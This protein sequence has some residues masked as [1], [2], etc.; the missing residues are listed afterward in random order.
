MQAI[1]AVTQFFANVSFT[2]VVQYYG[3][4]ILRN[5][6]RSANAGLDLGLFIKKNTLGDANLD[7]GFKKFGH[8]ACVLATGTAAATCGLAG[9][10]FGIGHTVWN[11]LGNL[12]SFGAITD[13]KKFGNPL[14]DIK[15][16]AR[17]KVT[18]GY[19]E[20]IKEKWTNLRKN[21]NNTTETDA[22]DK[23]EYLEVPVLKGILGGMTE[24]D[25]RR[26]MNHEFALDGEDE[27]KSAKKR[28]LDGIKDGTETETLLDFARRCIEAAKEAKDTEDTE[29]KREQ[30][31][32]VLDTFISVIVKE[33][34][35]SKDGLAAIKGIEF[36]ADDK[37]QNLMVHIND[38]LNG[39][40]G[41]FELGNEEHDQKIRELTILAINEHNT[42]SNS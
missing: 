9:G 6:Y 41:L 39:E 8:G 14:G 36:T 12:P 20:A 22:L 31:G 40:G 17:K 26:V 18:D 24:K 2:K 37:K 38:F 4:T 34:T 1:G 3:D 42:A 33:K 5:T 11:A 28:I 19:Y 10:V 27:K 29:K 23:L 13:A 7:T 15:N 30:A 25:I 21:T 35:G 32:I 16:A